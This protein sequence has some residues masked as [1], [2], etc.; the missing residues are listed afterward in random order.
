MQFE[1]VGPPLFASADTSK[2]VNPRTRALPLP[3][4][5]PGTKEF[6]VKEESSVEKNPNLKAEAE[7]GNIACGISGLARA[8]IRYFA[9]KG[10]GNWGIGKTISGAHHLKSGPLRLLGMQAVGVGVGVGVGRKPMA[11]GQSVSTPKLG[12]PCYRFRLRVLIMI[13][14]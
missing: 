6:G 8:L 11:R 14:T 9:G 4:R 1:S 3:L 10:D 13:T 7:S 5:K 12:A 2:T